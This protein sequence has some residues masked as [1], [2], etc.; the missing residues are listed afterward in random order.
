MRRP[1]LLACAL[2]LILT[3]CP[4][5]N[6]YGTPRTLPPGKTRILAAGGGTVLRDRSTNAATLSATGSVGFR[7]GIAKTVDLGA[8][9]GPGGLSGDVK[10]NFLRG[11]FDLAVA[12][13]FQIGASDK[14]VEALY[15]TLPLL[16]GLNLADTVTLYGSP[17]LLFQT[18]GGRY[19]LSDGVV[20]KSG[21]GVRV[22]FGFE[23]RATPAFALLPEATVLRFFG[24]DQAAI[25]H[26]G[27]GLA[28]GAQPIFKEEA[29][30]VQ[31]EEP[32]EEPHVEEI[33]DD[34]PTR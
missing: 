22:G 19:A 2:P 18:H 8:R 13:G 10:W 1:R 5:P 15:G 34:A 3:G 28:F 9:V 17:G 12:P 14:G 33:P 6:V 4:D 25:L 24:A 11:D 20:P 23:W 21:L 32:T 7:H 29:K 27:L 26:F 16:L 31:W 30:V